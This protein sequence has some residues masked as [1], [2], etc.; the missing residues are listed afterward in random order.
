MGKNH[1]ATSRSR[2]AF[3]KPHSTRAAS[4]SKANVPLASIIK[5]A[6]WKSDCVFQKFYNKP[7]DLD[8]DFGQAIQLVLS[9]S[10]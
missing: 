1:D 5:A 4:T 9:R 2:R 3:I 10:S 7:I 6:S 8:Q